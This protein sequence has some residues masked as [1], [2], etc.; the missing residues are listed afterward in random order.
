MAEADAPSPSGSTSVFNPAR[1]VEDNRIQWGTLLTTIF[2]ATV[3]A[4]FTG[5][6]D[7]IFSVADIPIAL[8]GGAAS[9]AGSVVGVLI[10]TPAVIIEQGFLAAIPFVADAGPAG[11]VAALAVGLAAAW[12]LAEVRSRVG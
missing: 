4:W 2:G 6:T 8:L 11:L 1:Y 10:G 12:V 7:L 3:G 5:L 9:F